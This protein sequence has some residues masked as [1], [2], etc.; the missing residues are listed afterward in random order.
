MGGK[1]FQNSASGVSTIVLKTMNEKKH[2]VTLFIKEKQEIPAFR[3]PWS[4]V[5]R[6]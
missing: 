2:P 1:H 4:P 3:T 6:E 5:S